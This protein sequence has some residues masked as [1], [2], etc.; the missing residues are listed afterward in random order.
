MTA[1]WE[2]AEQVKQ[3]GAIAGLG[4]SVAGKVPLRF[5]LVIPALNEEAAIGSTLQRA[6]AARE[7]VV[8]KT[9]VDE[10]VVVFVN[11]GSTDATQEIADRYPEVVKVRFEKNQGYGAAI[12]A[13]FL[14]TDAELVGFMDADGTCDPHF[15]V[16]LINHL[17]ETGADVVLGARLNPD[18]QMP[19]VRRLGNWIFARLVGAVSGKRLAD[20]A[21]G[22]RVIRRESLRKMVPL[23]DGLHFT[24]AMS[25]IAALDPRLCIREVPMPYRERVGRSK[26]SVARDG[27]RFLAIILFATACFNPIASLTCLGLLFAGLGGVLCWIAAA[28]GAGAVALA[29]LAG[30][31]VFVFVQAVFIGILCHQ[32]NFLLFGPRT[33]PGR[34]DR[35]IDR[36]LWTRPMVKA[37]ACVFLGGILCWAAACA[38]ATPRREFLWLVAALCTTGAGWLALGGVILRVI[39]A[40]R[41]K[42]RAGWV[43]PFARV[44]GRA[45]DKS[46]DAAPSPQAISNNDVVAAK[47]AKYVYPRV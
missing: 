34:M 32:L 25:C 1:I 40:A 46:P 3:G 6:L 8:A 45:G 5:A 9:P 47:E 30:S 31:F 10:M 29:V 13:G 39:W 21:S 23:P 26:L 36:L 19:L 18:S 41:E 35:L 11:D 7:E 38:S 14:A 2:T 42:Q 43:D 33:I 15:C 24:P 22:M 16:Q 37:A 17:C 4:E 27:L 44:A 28:C 20:V 12:K